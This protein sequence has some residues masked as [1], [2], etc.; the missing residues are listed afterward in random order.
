MPLQFLH[1]YPNCRVIIDCTEL[2]IQ[3]PCN[4]T[5]QQLTF[6]YYKNANTLKALVGIS[7]SGAVTFISDLW[8]SFKKILHFLKGNI[9]FT[10]EQRSENKAISNKRVHIERAIGRIKIFRY[11]EGAIPYNSLHNLNEVFFIVAFLTNF[12][13]PLINV[14]PLNSEK[15][16]K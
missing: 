7:P 6:S 16:K 13:K 15:K 12:N 1:Q 10:L 9:Q 2:E 14:L 4:P 5:E 3:R 11:F 8:V